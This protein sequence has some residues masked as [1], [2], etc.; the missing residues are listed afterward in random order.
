[1]AEFSEPANSVGR[2][3]D[4]G[5]A[6][7]ARARDWLRRG[8]SVIF[9]PE[10]TRSPDGEIHEFKAGAFKLALEEK[11]DL[12]PLVI[13]GTREAIPKRSWTIRE[14]RPL[15]FK[16]LETISVEGLGIED[17]DRLR[18]EVREKNMNEFHKVKSASISEG[19][20]R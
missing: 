15:F 5:R 7:L 19:R 6:C 2:D 20:E 13:V 1:M 10:G 16:V 17:L 4:S 18:T 3:R 9:F 14:R 8:V 12:L 11:V